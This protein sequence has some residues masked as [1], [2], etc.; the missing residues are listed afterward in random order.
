MPQLAK[1]GNYVF[2]WSLVN[3]AGR[4]TIPAN[5]RHGF[6]VVHGPGVE[7]LEVFT[8]PKKENR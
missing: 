2:G 6:S 8:P 3:S 1:G 4:I 7:Y 5:V